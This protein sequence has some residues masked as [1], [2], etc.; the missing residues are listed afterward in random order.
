[1]QQR[2]NIDALAAAVWRDVE[3]QEGPLDQIEDRR[4]LEE[5]LETI[6]DGALLLHVPI[7]DWRKI[8]PPIVWER[9]EAAR[10]KRRP[11]SYKALGIRRMMVKELKQKFAEKR[12]VLQAIERLT[13]EEAFEQV[14][15][16]VA[17]DWLMPSGKPRPGAEFVSGEQLIRWY[18]NPAR[19]L[20]R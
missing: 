20:R 12:R 3:A 11:R 19:Y 14:A 13:R 9:I 7:R 4:I 10:P 1:M 16:E 18:A 2:R 5:A 6:Q 8:V 17:A 15:R